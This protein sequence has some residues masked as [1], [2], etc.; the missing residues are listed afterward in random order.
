[1][2]L[3]ELQREW[4]ALGATDPFGSIAT[5]L[6]GFCGERS[7]DEMFASGEREISAILETLRGLG[8]GVNAGIALDFGCGAGRLTQAL[9]RRFQSVY[10]VD[11]APS[12]IDQAKRLGRSERCHY[13]MNSRDDL[14]IFPPAFFD[15]IYTNR[16]LQYLEP[17]HSTKYIAEFLRVLRPGGVLVFDLPDR[18]RPRGAAVR[19]EPAAY[20]AQ[21]QFL[22]APAEAGPGQ[23]FDVRAIV[24]NASPVRWPGKQRLAEGNLIRL[25]NHWLDADGKGEIRDD[26]RTA[27]PHDLDPGAEVQLILRVRAPQ[28]LDS[29]LL[30]LDLVHEQ[31]LWFSDV[32]SG[33]ARQNILVKPA[34]TVGSLPAEEH[35]SFHMERYN[36]PRSEVEQVISIAGGRLLHVSESTDSDPDWISYLYVVAK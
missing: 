24:R 19:M 23:S 28:R 29:F 15:F 31:M 10:G 11:I 34:A 18:V 21:I 16:V 5:D 6:A 26:G 14:R 20:N 17:R 13:M 30:E 8:L 32:G 36:V 25:G 2:E 1:M 12:M 3:R 35:K 22:S 33:T 7:P 4:D 9:G 27:L